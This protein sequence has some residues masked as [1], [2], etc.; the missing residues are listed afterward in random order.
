MDSSSWCKLLINEDESAALAAFVDH[1]HSVGGGFLSADL[2]VTEVWRTVHRI[3]HDSGNVAVD[4]ANVTEV[5]NRVNLFTPDRSIYRDAAHLFAGQA[6]RSLDA[7]H[8]AQC[9]AVDADVFISYDERQLAAA[10]S[11]GIKTHSPR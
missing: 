3:D 10:R 1:V 4:P 9:L 11:V 5:L 2:L 6:V 8:V 7:I